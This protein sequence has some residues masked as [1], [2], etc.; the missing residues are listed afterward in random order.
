M[1][2]RFNRFPLENYFMANENVFFFLAVALIQNS[3]EISFLLFAKVIF[4]LFFTLFASS[5]F[6]SPFERQLFFCEPSTSKFSS[7]FG[8]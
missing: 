1:R 3:E 4:I 8:E 7:S 5:F 2:T 6:F